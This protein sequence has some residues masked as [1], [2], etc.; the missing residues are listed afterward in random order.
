M[1]PRAMRVVL[2]PRALH[3]LVALRAY[4]ARNNPAAAYAYLHDDEPD[5]IV[6]W[7]R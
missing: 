4:I 1:G 2:L 7:C 5:V 3:D 6:A